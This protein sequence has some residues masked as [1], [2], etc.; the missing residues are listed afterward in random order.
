MQGYISFKNNAPHICD[1]LVIFLWIAVNFVPWTVDQV[2]CSIKQFISDFVRKGVFIHRG[3]P[4]SN[5]AA[6]RGHP[7][8]HAISSLGLVVLLLP[9]PLPTRR[10]SAF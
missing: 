3:P 4:A 8:D 6:L 7:P 9:S 5:K 1:P 10:P 2:F